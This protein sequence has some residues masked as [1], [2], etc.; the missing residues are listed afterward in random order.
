MKCRIN[1]YRM[2]ILEKHGNLELSDFFIL[3]KIKKF[4]W[5]FIETGEFKKN[6]LII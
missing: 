6:C 2:S 4:L 5:N 1:I 3:G